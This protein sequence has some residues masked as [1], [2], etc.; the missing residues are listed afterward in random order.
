LFQF[1]VQRYVHV[2][3]F[4]VLLTIWV[5]NK[6]RSPLLGTNVNHVSAVPPRL[7]CFMIY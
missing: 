5:D 2:S 6:K 7:G 1:T 4:A 3:S